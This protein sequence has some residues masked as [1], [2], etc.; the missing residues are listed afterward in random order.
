MGRRKFKKKSR[1]WEKRNQVGGRKRFI[2]DFLSQE[3]PL[4]ENEKIQ[5][6]SERYIDI[7]KYQKCFLKK[8]S[9]QS[10]KNLRNIIR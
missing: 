10:M 3:Y 7:E 2:H 5:K 8:Q 1:E 4:K 6:K 9:K